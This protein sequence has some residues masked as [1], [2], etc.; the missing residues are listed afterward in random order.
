M[1]ECNQQ[2]RDHWD[3]KLAQWRAHQ[4]V[5]IDESAINSK[6]SQRTHGWGKKG[7]RIP[8][9]VPARKA[10]NLSLLP[11][12]TVDGY[13]VCNLY[14]GA[15]NAERFL[16]FI[17]EVLPL[18]TPFPGPRSIIIMDNASIHRADVSP[19]SYDTGKLNA[20]ATLGNPRNRRGTWVPTRIPS[21]LFSR[22]Q[23]NRILFLGH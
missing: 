1:Q 6:L 19:L 10:K 17:E 21:S 16:A 22:L 11:A 23:S 12:L 7:D 5:F 20:N 18:C 8:H 3:S 2:L 9:K 13:I 14:E 15:V 4:L